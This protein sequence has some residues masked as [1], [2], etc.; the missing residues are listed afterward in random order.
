MRLTTANPGASFLAGVVHDKKLS[1]TAFCGE[2]PLAHFLKPFDRGCPAACGAKPLLCPHLQR[3][4]LG[5]EKVYIIDRQR[6]GNEHPR[7]WSERKLETS[8]TY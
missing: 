7:Q 1:L 4:L 3:M 5:L 6:Q 2:K 8:S